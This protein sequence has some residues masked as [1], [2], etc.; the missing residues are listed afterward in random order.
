MDIDKLQKILE[1]NQSY[2]ETVTSNID[3]LQK[4]L[5]SNSEK[6][7]LLKSK[8]PRYDDDA[9]IR[10]PKRVDFFKIPHHTFKNMDKSTGTITPSIHNTDIQQYHNKLPDFKIDHSHAKLTL[11]E[12]R[13]LSKGIANN[14][15]ILY[16][17]DLHQQH[18]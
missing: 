1:L 10:G 15:R 4:I 18:S 13:A 5:R 3:K 17:E 12:Q 9:S 8:V 6:Q 2:Q 11:C 14:I 7:R 16:L